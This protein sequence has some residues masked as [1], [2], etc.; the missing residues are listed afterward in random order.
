MRFLYPHADLLI[1]RMPRLPVAEP[2]P[3][4]PAGPRA[5][6]G[7]RIA[8]TFTAPASAVFC[9]PIIWLRVNRSTHNL[10]SDAGSRTR[11]SA[12]R[13]LCPG[14]LNDIAIVLVP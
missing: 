7:Q 5:T 8:A 13:V 12:L 10:G 6:I 9:L 14:L 2:G 3:R 4:L 11:F 1:D